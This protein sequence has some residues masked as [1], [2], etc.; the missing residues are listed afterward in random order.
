MSLI[1]IIR[2]LK[3]KCHWS[4]L[5]SHRSIHW[6]EWQKI[7]I[8]NDGHWQKLATPSWVYQKLSYH[9]NRRRW[10]RDSFHLQWGDEETRTHI[11]MK[12]ILISL[13]LWREAHYQRGH[14]KSQD[15]R[16]IPS[17]SRVQLD[18]SPWL[19]SL[20]YWSPPPSNCSPLSFSQRLIIIET[21]WLPLSQLHFYLR[22]NYDLTHTVSQESWY[23]QS[24]IS[25]RWWPT[26]AMT[27]HYTIM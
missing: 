12:T 18:S 4:W 9:H 6:Q 26:I 16:L 2:T 23:L 17:Q 22:R 24:V 1:L 3:T 11:I 19:H 5:A 25:H 27:S 15:W 21:Y 10:Q 20:C 13:S 8:L 7:A 14:A